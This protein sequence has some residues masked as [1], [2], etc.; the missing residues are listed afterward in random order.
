MWVFT[1]GA[2]L[3]TK[4]SFTHGEAERLMREEGLMSLYGMGRATEGARPQ[5]RPTTLYQAVNLAPRQIILIAGS[6]GK[7]MGARPIRKDVLL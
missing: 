2:I 3:V 4:N 5:G 7:T 6:K 1:R